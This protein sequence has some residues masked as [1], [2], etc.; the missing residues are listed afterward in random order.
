MRARVSL[1]R[2]PYVTDGFRKVSLWPS[3]A[4]LLWALMARP[5]LT[6]DEAIPLIWPAPDREPDWP[7][8]GV[9]VR[10]CRLR[11][12]LAEMGISIKTHQRGWALA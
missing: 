10:M 9:R 4:T 11:K 12:N 8:A 5:R 2:K 3:E 1:G 7:E 6:V